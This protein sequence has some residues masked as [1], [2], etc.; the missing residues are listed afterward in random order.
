MA[1]IAL[2]QAT[3]EALVREL[4]S[5][6]YDWEVLER[7]GLSFSKLRHIE[8]LTYLRRDAPRFREI[9][10]SSS[11]GLSAFDTTLL[12]R[13]LSRRPDLAAALRE[14][15]L[16]A[17]SDFQCTFDESPRDGGCQIKCDGRSCERAQAKC[18]S[19]GHCVSVD[20][21]RDKT[22]ATLKSLQAVLPPP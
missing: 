7:A 10:N 5:R 18:R 16:G 21:N 15:G 3:S 2:G 9:L 11:L 8:L 13:T 19:L 6:H 20:V 22:W 17:G 1:S 14:T 4:H 12:L